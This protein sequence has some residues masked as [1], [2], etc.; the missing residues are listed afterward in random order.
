M[1][2]KK[3]HSLKTENKELLDQGRPRAFAQRSQISS[4]ARETSGFAPF[5]WRKQALCEVIWLA[6]KRILRYF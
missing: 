4:A 3:Y 2:K 6:Q 1:F 5:S